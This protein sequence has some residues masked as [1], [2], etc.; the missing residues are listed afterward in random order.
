[1]EYPAMGRM[2]DILQREPLHNLTMLALNGHISGG[3]RPDNSALGIA[4]RDA[5]ISIHRL[6]TRT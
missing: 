1:M 6:P 4:S 5:S 2:H 3:L